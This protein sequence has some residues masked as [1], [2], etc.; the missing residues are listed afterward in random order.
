VAPKIVSFKP[1]GR[2]LPPSVR[3]VTVKFDDYIYGSINSVNIYK[4]GSST[5]LALR[6]ELYEDSKRVL[7]DP[8]KV[9]K[10]DTWYTVKVTTGVNDGAN[11]LEAPKSWSFKTRG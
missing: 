3:D 11:N 8:K 9:L 2:Q 7:I 1:T 5:P 6:R 4:R 10:H